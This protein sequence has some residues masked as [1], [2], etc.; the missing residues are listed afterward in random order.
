M[1]TRGWY[2]Y[3]VVN[4]TDRTIS[5][6]MQFYKWGDAIP[7]NALCELAALKR[8]LQNLNGRLPVFL[9]DEMLRE[10]LG[11]GYKQLPQSFPVG[12]YLFLL[13]RAQEEETAS[14][15]LRYAGM[16]KE[17]RPDYQYGFQIGYAQGRHKV[18]LQEY[19]DEYVQ[20][21]NGSIIAG[22]FVRP[23]S[24]YSL[25]HSFLIW[26]QYL[27]QPTMDVDMGSIAGDYRAPFDIS[28]IYRFFIFVPEIDYGQRIVDIRLQVCDRGG[29]D[30]LA[31]NWGDIQ[32]EKGNE[33]SYKADVINELRDGFGSDGEK[34]YSL[35]EAV[36]AYEMIESKFWET[37]SGHRGLT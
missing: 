32:K 22:S 28:Y 8:V 30:L 2:E 31:G 12:C 9:L 15:K 36:E 6:S 13:Q 37:N 26:L 24:D 34:P 25:K 10:Q 35:Q 29:T 11:A 7:W 3:Y 21:A 17:E 16:R 27:T 5:L 1:S 14:K 23:W 20:S 4:E 18:S 33:S 19:P